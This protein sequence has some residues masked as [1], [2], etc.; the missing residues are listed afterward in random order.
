M[1]A[2]APAASE[3]AAALPHGLPGGAAEKLAKLLAEL[4]RWNRRVNLT[5]ITDPED[6][7]SLHVLDSLSIR[8]FLN[9]LRVIDVGTGAGFPGLVL[10]I[11]EPDVEFELLD[12]NAKKI[13][14]VRHAI[15]EI[16]FSNAKA[17]KARVED[18][19]PDKRFDTVIARAL[20][21]LPR[22]ID[23]AGHLVAEDGVMLALKGRYPADEL[24]AM[25]D[26]WGYSVSKLTV[27]GL[28]ARHLVTLRRRKTG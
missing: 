2:E 25:P 11:A 18:Y 13:S 21:T 22:L 20:A 9:G 1:I 14:F 15:G 7:I 26:A 10:A 8:T 3:L 19:A 12:S 24:K 6:M 28:D 23:L 17:I 16:G 5:A 27:P 4:L